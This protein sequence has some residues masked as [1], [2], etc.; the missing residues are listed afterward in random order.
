LPPSPCFNRWSWAKP[1]EVWKADF[2][3]KVRA[4]GAKTKTKKWWVTWDVDREMKGT[5]T[6]E[7]T[8]RGAGLAR[9]LENNNL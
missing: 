9:S 8:F 2:T 6:L 3:F 1:K 5:F 4:K 7:R